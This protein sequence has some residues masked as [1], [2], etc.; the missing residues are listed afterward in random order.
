MNCA[1]TQLRENNSCF[2]CMNAVS[3]PIISR[4]YIIPA[5]SSY[6]SVF[7]LMVT[8][9]IHFQKSVCHSFHQTESRY[10]SRAPWPHFFCCYTIQQKTHQML[11]AGLFDIDELLQSTF[12]PHSLVE[13][14]SVYIADEISPEFFPPLLGLTIIFL[15][16]Y[17]C[18][19]PAFALW[20]L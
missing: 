8:V 17:Q 15:L 18:P 4:A 5:P 1:E 9:L 13:S 10:K 19:D 11:P 12:T 14:L 20:C 2:C 7:M 3:D 6:M 16:P